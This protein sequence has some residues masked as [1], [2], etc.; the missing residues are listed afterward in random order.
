GSPRR[1][2]P[3]GAAAPRLIFWAA[4]WGLRAGDREVIRLIGP[5]GAV[6]AERTGQVPGDRAEW[7]RYVGRARAGATWPAGRYRGEYRVERPA[8]GQTETVIDT[9]AETQIP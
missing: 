4:A 5:K 9:V 2:R 8:H 7:L 1:A 6:L 3:P